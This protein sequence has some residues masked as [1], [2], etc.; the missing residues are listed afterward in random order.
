MKK[1]LVFVFALLV[2]SASVFA[3]NYREV[4]Y[5]KNGSVIKGDVLEQVAG[6]NIKIKTADG[7]LFVYPSSDV[8]KVVKEEVK[9]GSTKTTRYYHTLGVGSKWFNE[10]EF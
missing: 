7:S 3:Q 6:G 4:V 8:V 5:L 1:I 2:C 10:I 9:G